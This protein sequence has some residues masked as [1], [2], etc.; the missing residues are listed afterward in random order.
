MSNEPSYLRVSVQLRDKS[1]RDS[2]SIDD[3]TVIATKELGLPRYRSKKRLNEEIE[4]SL[5][6]IRTLDTI[7]RI[8]SGS[9]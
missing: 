5:E 9:K 1:L 2:L 6:N 7:A 8:A 3:L 4:I